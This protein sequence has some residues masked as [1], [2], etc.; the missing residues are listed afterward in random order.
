[1]ITLLSGAKKNLGDYLIE[2]HGRD[3]IAQN[4]DADVLVWPRW[5]SPSDEV[6][7]KVN[8]SSAIVLCG[9]P[10]FKSNVPFGNR[11]F[12]RMA[13]LR[14]PLVLLAG[15]WKAPIGDAEDL[16]GFHFDSKSV[17]FL[18]EISAKYP[19]SVRDVLTE[20]ILR[21]HGIENVEMTGCVVMYD[22]SHLHKRFLPPERISRV[23]FSPA[24]LPKLHSQSVYL[25]GALRQLF[26]HAEIVASFNRGIEPDSH[27]S[28]KESRSL[29]RMVKKFQGLGI[30][31]KDVA[32]GAQG[33]DFYRGT[34]LHVG[35]RVHSH[36]K[37]LSLRKPSYLLYEDC[38][39][40]GV[41]V[42]LK[43]TGFPAIRR[44]SWGWL[45]REPV[46]ALPKTQVIDRLVD[47]L[48]RDE[49]SHFERFHEVFSQ[50]DRFFGPMQR[51]LKNL[52]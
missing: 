23:V 10:F 41:D 51:F 26:P 32:Y 46:I 30:A 35:Y 42:S 19:I 44:S 38:R 13:Q 17:N 18:K 37:F 24:Q 12:D 52:P 29:K 43:S 25:A 40:L 22:A 39:G 49:E 3:L 11:F 36:L 28:S 27:T 45:S 16:E 7:E 15:G 34:D 5:E 9:G 21:R 6:L 31:I 14:P 20:E 48:S 47:L 4:R 2:A 1:M 8:R 33:A 50:L